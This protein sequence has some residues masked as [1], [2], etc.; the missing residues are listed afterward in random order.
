MKTILQFSG[1]KDSLACLYL[2]E[3]RWAQIEVVWV[4]TGAAFPETLEQM[5][6]IRKLVPHFHEIQSNQNIED[7]G[8]PVDVVPLLS[9]MAGTAFEGYSGPVFQSRYSCC[10]AALWNPMVQTMQALKP[11]VIIRGQKRTDRNRVPIAHGEVVHGV[12]YQFPLDTWTDADVYAYLKERGIPLPRNYERMATGLDCWNCTAYLGE[13]AGKLDY[14]HE[15]HPAKY[16]HVHR[17]LVE[18]NHVLEH[19]LEPLRNA[20]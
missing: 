10:A 7:Q 6:R 3:P 14:L 4:N 17:V 18:Y 9:T 11:D 15:F 2:L 16:L 8:Y 20:L 1:G 5:E 19:T 12:E 13:N